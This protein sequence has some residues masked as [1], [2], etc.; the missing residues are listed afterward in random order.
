[1]KRGRFITF[2]GPEG[3]GKSTHVRRL[4]GR[5]ENCGV[6]VLLTREPGGTRT[7]EAIRGILQHDTA[8]EPLSPRAELLLFEASRAQLVSAVIEP[9]LASGKWVICDRF[10]DS[11]T[12]YQ[13]YGR[14]FGADTVLGLNAF[15]VGQTVPDLTLLLDIPVSRGLDRIEKRAVGGAGRDRIER[16]EQTFHEAVRNG[17]MA[18][19]ARWPDRIKVVKTDRDPDAVHED[20]WKVV[21]TALG[22]PAGHGRD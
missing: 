5:L 16:E 22:L 2:E 3:S 6:N 8:G 9:A 10:A 4:A 13:G 12:A 15:A 7:G 21:S 18:L 1:M 14:G 20:I 17:F 19:A 11:S